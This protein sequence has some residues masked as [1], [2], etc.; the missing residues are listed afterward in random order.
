VGILGSFGG[1]TTDAK[2]ES[3]DVTLAA[4]DHSTVSALVVGTMVLIFA[5]LSLARASDVP[6][7]VTVS[8]APFTAQALV[9]V[10]LQ[11]ASGVE[12]LLDGCTAV[13]F[14]RLVGGAWQPGPDR[15]C[16]GDELPML[17]TRELTIS[18]PSPGPGTWRAVV[19]WGAGC[20]S[21]LPL[22][23]ASCASLGAQ[24]TGSFVIEDV[25]AT[26]P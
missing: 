12:V 7:A 25:S 18:L 26:S 4:A 2:S 10:A 14:E 9:P 19:T 24:R 22:A 20:R 6:V 3:S 5:L 23:F 15:A 8:G 1:R 16:R 13:E 17:V 21:G 11:V